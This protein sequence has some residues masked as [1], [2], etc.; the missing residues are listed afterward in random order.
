MA[1]GK[2]TRNNSSSELTADQ[3]L[4]LLLSDMAEIKSDN[5]QF[6]AEINELT[7]EF[8]QFKSDISS[9]IELCFG[10][11]EDCNNIVSDNTKKIFSQEATIQN[12]QCEI[13]NLKSK[14][15]NLQQTANLS[16]QYLRSNSL[17]IRGVPEQKNENIM[18]VVKSVAR[19]LNFELKDNMVDAVHRLSLNPKNPPA[20]RGII[21]K[22]CRRIDMEQMRAKTRVKNGFPAQELGYQ[23]AS[24]IYISLSLTKEVWG[25]WTEVRSFKKQYE[26][27]YAWITSVGKIFLR[28]TDGSR[29]VHIAKSNDLIKLK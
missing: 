21:L 11:I 24:D 3:K 20:P 29:A 13:N 23:S 27:K 19:A 6:K 18:N 1:P 9:S 8:K 15:D 16:N 10:K 25:L 28:K 26:Y 17:E 14:C 12:L 5:K 22:F 7:S 2:N 4:D